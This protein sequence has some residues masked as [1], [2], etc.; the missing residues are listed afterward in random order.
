M[1]GSAPYAYNADTQ[2]YD[3]PT[4]SKAILETLLKTNATQ[5]QSLKLPGGDQTVA[6]LARKVSRKENEAT[7]GL[8]SVMKVLTE[9]KE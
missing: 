8:Q 5:L 3:Q 4:I 2:M 7:K 6:D 1:D 9:Q